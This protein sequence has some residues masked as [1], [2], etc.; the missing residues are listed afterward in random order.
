MLLPIRTVKLLRLFGMDSEQLDLLIEDL[1]LVPSTLLTPSLKDLILKE[2]HFREFQEFNE[3]ERY[4]QEQYLKKLSERKK[5]QQP[6][7]SED[8]LIL[9]EDG[10]S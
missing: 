6:V 7:I 5:K 8:D 4:Y 1:G 10:L 2:Q 3:Y 9:F